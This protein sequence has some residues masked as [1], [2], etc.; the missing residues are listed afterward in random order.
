MSVK[1]DKCLINFLVL[2]ST[3]EAFDRICFLSGKSRTQVL[4]EMMKQRIASAGRKFV[5]E[6]EKEAR[7]NDQLKALVESQTSSETMDQPRQWSEAVRNRLNP[8]FTA[9]GASA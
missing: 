3:V 4:T 5:L 8:N 6:A 2:F 1:S 9:N 7:L